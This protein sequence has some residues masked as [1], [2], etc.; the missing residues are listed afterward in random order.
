[1]LIGGDGGGLAIFLP[2]DGDD[3]KLSFRWWQKVCSHYTEIDWRE[4]VP[5]YFLRLSYKRT[6]SAF[7]AATLQHALLIS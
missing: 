7:Y 1:M 6:P 5:F 3:K 2:W 4:R